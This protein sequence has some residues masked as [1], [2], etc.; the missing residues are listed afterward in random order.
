MKVPGYVWKCGIIILFIREFRK[1]ADIYCDFL[2]NREDKN[3]DDLIP[4]SVR[5]LYS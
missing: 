3:D 4:D 1:C 2:I 5:H